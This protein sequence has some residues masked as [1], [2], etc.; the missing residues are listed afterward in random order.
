M[1]TFCEVSLNRFEF[2]AGAVDSKNRF[3]YDELEQIEAILEDCYPEGVDE[4]TVND[5]FWFEP[6]TLC[7]WLE[8]DFDEWVER[9]DDYWLH[10]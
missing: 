1:K 6:E 7:E 2:W 3:S 4:T 10:N 5:I 8:I 9:P